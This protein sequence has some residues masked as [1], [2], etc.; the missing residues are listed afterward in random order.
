MEIKKRGR[1]Q[2]RKKG[3]QTKRNGEI[4]AADKTAKKAGN[5]ELAEPGGRQSVVV[6]AL[7]GSSSASA[8]FADGTT[9]AVLSDVDDFG[10]LGLVIFG[11]VGVT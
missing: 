7:R 8:L 10:V 4:M 11:W 6:G 9:T 5:Q 1:R 3:K 2:W